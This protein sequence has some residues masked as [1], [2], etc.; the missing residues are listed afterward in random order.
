MKTVELRILSTVNT[1][2]QNINTNISKS[3]KPSNRPN[4][5][6]LWKTLLERMARINLTCSSGDLSCFVFVFERAGTRKCCAVARQS[7]ASYLTGTN[8]APLWIMHVVFYSSLIQ[9]SAGLLVSF[10]CKG[11]LGSIAWQDPIYLKHARALRC[12]YSHF[13][14]TSDCTFLFQSSP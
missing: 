14:V 12:N 6:L 7:I 4:T 5:Q 8:L 11:R 9:C 3:W 13:N 2:K 1:P 10:R